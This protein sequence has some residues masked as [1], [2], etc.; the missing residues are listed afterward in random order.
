MLKP[1]SQK[2]MMYKNFNSLPPIFKNGHFI[3]VQFWKTNPR[4]EKNDEN[5]TQSI[6]LTNAF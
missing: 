2:T 1:P 3:N 6:M 5:I 4:F